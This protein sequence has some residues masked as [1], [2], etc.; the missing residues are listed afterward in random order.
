MFFAATIFVT[1]LQRNVSRQ[2]IECPG[3]TLPYMCSIKSN[4]ESMQLRWL[5]TFPGQ[6]TI[7]ILYTDG[8]NLNRVTYLPMNLTARLTQFSSGLNVESAI[9]LTVLQ[10]VSMNGT[11]LQCSS[12]V[13]ILNETVYV[14]TSGILL[15]FFTF[16]TKLS[17][18]HTVPLTP[19]GF[20]ITGVDYAITNV[21]VT[22]E[23]DGAQGSGPEAIV[24]NYIV[25]ITPRPLF[26]SSVNMLPNSQLALEV[27]LNHN[28]IYM[29]SIT[30]ENCAGRSETFV[31]PIGIQHGL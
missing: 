5:V 3:D 28:T 14:N 25:N 15:Q 4:S 23:W 21:T 31:Y 20:N 13:A 8:S 2:D 27:T 6:D 1:P 17:C 22:F 16:W 10:N 26:P 29:A 9:E 7:M 24:D 19:S 12:K 30:A 11:V 18:V